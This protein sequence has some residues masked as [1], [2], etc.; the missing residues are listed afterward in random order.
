MPLLEAANLQKIYKSR[1]SSVQVEALRN[2]SFS[3]EAG[4]FVAVMGESGS[5]KTTLLNILAAI[6]R[7]DRG[8]LRLNGQNM[9]A[10]NSREISRFRRMHL[11][12]VFQDYALLD[13]F[14]IKD[15]ILL[16]LVLNREKYP[17][18]KERLER[19]TSALSLGGLLERYPDE[20]S[21]GQK[22][23]V[24]IARA[25][26]AR[27]ELLLADEPTGAL[28]S[29]NAWELLEL[30]SHLNENGQTII[31]VTHSVSAA[32]FASRVLFIRDGKIFHQLYRGDQSRE[33]FFEQI[34][35]AQTL[36]NK[37]KGL[38]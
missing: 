37:R 12:Y 6:D 1:F 17:V 35:N 2:I 5:G 33:E 23:R 32:S 22:Q 38:V 20:L 8:S 14:P 31:M 15:N 26:I 4:E 11:G 30:F 24:A 34:L 13:T 25:L 10:L 27:P 21:G 28:D 7:P 29:S 16:P 19:I 18:M 3:I 9:L 36:I